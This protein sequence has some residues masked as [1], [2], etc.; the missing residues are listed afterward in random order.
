MAWYIYKQF[1]DEE[2]YSPSFTF[3]DFAAFSAVSASLREGKRVDTVLSLVAR[4]TGQQD[5]VLG[6]IPDFLTIASKHVAS[7]GFRQLVEELEPGVHQFIPVTLYD[8]DDIP[9]DRPYWLLNPQVVVDVELKSERLEELRREGRVPSRE[10]AHARYGR[11]YLF[12]E[13]SAIEGRHFWRIS[14]DFMPDLYF[15]DELIRRVRLARLRKL[16]LNCVIPV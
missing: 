6:P 11:R 1:C 8:R 5:Y 4:R 7:D 10:E 2:R 9:V 15:S 13:R 12:A 3:P 14:R 16:S